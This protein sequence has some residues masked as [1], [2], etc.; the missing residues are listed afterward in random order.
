MNT[1]SSKTFYKER[2]AHKER[3]REEK[4]KCEAV[5]RRK[6]G[7]FV[8]SVLEHHRCHANQLERAEGLQEACSMMQVCVCVSS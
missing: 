8:K 6:K 2:L 3:L 1:V 7:A 5:L 4:E